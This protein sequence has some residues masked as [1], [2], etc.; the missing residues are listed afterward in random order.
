MLQRPVGDNASE[1]T[2]SESLFTTDD[3]RGK[4]RPGASPPSL[5][6]KMS[7]FHWTVRTS[8]ENPQTICLGALSCNPFHR[9][10]QCREERKTQGWQMRELL[11]VG[12][13]AQRVTKN[14]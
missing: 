10:I 6:L 13:N 1:L 2:P 4:V 3:E 12:S 5:L 7:C 8:N 11:G 9:R 14:K